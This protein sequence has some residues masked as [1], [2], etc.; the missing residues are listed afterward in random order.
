MDAFPLAGLF[1]VLLILICL[2][3][4][5]SGSETA[6]MS[7]NH[8]RL[9]ARARRGQRA[10]ILTLRLLD[11][12]E[13]LIGLILMCNTTVN[14]VAGVLATLI[15]LRLSGESGVAIATGILTFVLLIFGEVAPKTVAAL[16]PDRV[17]LPS[18]FVYNVIQHPLRPIVWLVT[19]V[20]K[21]VLWA[22]GIH[23]DSVMHHNLNSEELR[24]AVL[25]AG[26]VI[27]KRHQRMLLSVLDLER[28]TVE[29]IMVPRSDIVGFDISEPW[30]QLRETIV[31]AQHTR[32]PVFDGSVDTLIGVVHMRSVVA[33]AAAGKLELDSFLKLA[34]T[35]YFI[36]EG[37]PLNRQLLNFQTQQRR[38]GFVVDEYGDIQ[39]LVALE[40]ILEEVVGDFTSDPAVGRKSVERRADGSVVAAGAASIR[41]LNRRLGWRLPL[42]DARTVNGL[43][44][45]Q[46]QD[47]PKPGVRLRVGDY[48]IEVIDIDSN[49]VRTARIRPVTRVARAS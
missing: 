9:K 36:P 45:E 40:D 29:D 42:G 24:A 14:I 13:P 49:S 16:N 1:A 44:L 30:E 33:L 8:Y 6:L 39:G 4:F 11:R 2:S 41:S 46:L 20:A 10:A 27:P 19:H 38:L 43:V 35:P 15:G 37:T 28:S 26:T 34:R 3:A 12:P 48:D 7:I 47:L 25:E 5:F 32:V 23:S 31:R 18:S 17:A 22:L 21:G